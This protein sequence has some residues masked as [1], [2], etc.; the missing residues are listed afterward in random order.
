M[1][2]KKDTSKLQKKAIIDKK[3]KRTTVYV[4]MAGVESKSVLTRILEF[5]GF[6]NKEQ[7][8]TMVRTEY[9]K[10]NIQEKFDITPKEWMNHVYEYF[11]HKNKWDGYFSS[12]PASKTAVTNKKATGRPSEK[13]AM[14]LHPEGH[15][16][17]LSVL[18]FIHDTYQKTQPDH[19]SEDNF[20][21]MPGTGSTL[22]KI[23]DRIHQ[24]SDMLD[25]K[26]KRKHVESD[27]VITRIDDK[28][29]HYKDI[30]GNG[31]GM[32]SFQSYK[33]MRASGELTPV[34]ENN[35]DTMPDVSQM[36]ISDRVLEAER[37][38]TLAYQNGKTATPALDQKVIN[39]TAGLPLGGGGNKI[40]AAWSN[41]W[42]RANL[43]ATGGH[44]PV[45]PATTPAPNPDD[46]YQE[47]QEAA[48]TT[49]YGKNFK[50]MEA[51]GIL[52]VK[53]YA[54]IEN[55]PYMPLSIDR[56]R[57][58]TDKDGQYI[59]FAIAHNYIQNGDVM[60]DPDMEIRVRPQFGS[61][62]ALTFQNDGVGVFTEVYPEAGK[63]NLRAKKDLNSFLTTWLNNLK[64][65]G[66]QYKLGETNGPNKS[67]AGSGEVSATDATVLAGAA[68]GSTLKDVPETKPG[69]YRGELVLDG[70]EFRERSAADVRLTPKQAKEIREQVHTLLNS[71][72]DDAM[73]DTEKALLMQ[74]EGAGGLHE[75]EATTH[76]TLYEFYTPKTVVDK[77]W[78]LTE[79]YAGKG[80]EVLEPSCGTGRFANRDG[81]KFDMIEIDPTSARIA[82]ILNP[83]QNVKQ[84]AFQEIFYKNGAP[85]EKYSGKKY[86]V[87]IGNPPYGEYSGIHKGKGE[88]KSHKR[89]E[90]YFID[91]GLDVLKEGGIMTFVVP[92]DFL[93]KES[94]KK[95][96]EKLA[97][98]GRLLE[99]WRLPNGTFNT[100]GVG[101]DILV[102]R[103][104]KGNVAD[105]LGDG[106]FNQ[107]P[108]CILGEQVTKTGKFGPMKYVQPKDNM[109]FADVFN[110]LNTN[111]FNPVSVGQPT[112]TEE[113]KQKIAIA[114]QGNQNAASAHDV[115]AKTKYS[116]I[117]TKKL[118][119]SYEVMQKK[120]D[121]TEQQ[122]NNYSEMERELL[123]RGTIK[124]PSITDTVDQSKFRKEVQQLEK[125][126]KTGKE[127]SPEEKRQYRNVTDKLQIEP[128]ATAIPAELQGE[129]SAQEFSAKYNKQ[130]DALDLDIWKATG[131][132]GAVD[133]AKLSPKARD[134]FTSSDKYCMMAGK[135]YHVS[136]YVSGDIYAKLD[137]LERDKD[138]MPIGLYN[139]QKELLLKAMPAR[140]TIQNVSVSPISEYAKTFNFGIV[141]TPDM[142]IDKFYE[143]ATGKKAD[144]YYGK[145]GMN[146]DGNV[147]R[148]DFPAGIGWSDVVDYIEQKPVRASNKGDKA[149]NQAI[150][151]RTREMRRQ[152][153]EKLFKRFLETGLSADDQKTFEDRHNRIFNSNVDPD[154]SNIPIFVNGISKTFK[155]KELVVQPHQL[156]GTSFLCN[157]GNGLIAYDV[158]LGKTLVGAMATVNQIQTTRAKRPVLCIPK[159]VYEN[160]LAEIRDLFP[161]IKINELGN[162][163]SQYI[164]NGNPPV[165]EE[166]TLSVMTYEA[167]QNMTFHDETLG[168]V[169]D[170]II[171]GGIA[172]DMLDS[173]QTTKEGMTPREEAQQTEKILEMV[174]R[175]SKTKDNM[176]Y[177]EDL[178]FDHITIDEVHNF[179][180]VFARAKPTGKEGQA[181]A[182]EFGDITGSQSDRAMKMFAVTQYIQKNNN[183]R[184]VFALSATPFTNSPLEI[185][186]ILSL[187][188]RKKLK[189]LGIY[190]LHE[191]MAKFAKL[192]TEWV[193]ATDG[194]IKKKAVMKEFQNLG[195]LQNLIIEYIDKID[196]EE[197]GIER[198]RDFNHI[199]ELPMTADQRA[200]MMAEQER[201]KADKDE[202]PGAALK[203]IN[204]MRMSTMSMKMVNFDKYHQ[205][206]DISDTKLVEDSPKLKF[207]A[208]V[209]ANVY[210]ERPEVGQVIYMPR[211]IEHYGEVV[212]YLIS[213]GIPRDAI[214]TIH[215]QMAGGRDKVETIKAEFNDPKGKIKVLIGSET[216][217][218]GINLNGNS[219][220]LYNTLLGWNPS[221]RT[222][223]KGRIWRQGNLQENVHIVYPQIINSVDSAMYQKH[224]EKGARFEQVWSYKGDNLNVED[225]NAEELKFSLIKDP[226]KRAKFQLDLELEKIDNDKRDIRIGIDMLNKNKEDLGNAAYR[227]SSVKDDIERS[228][229]TLAT[230]Q[231]DYDEVKE[232]YDA[233][234]KV[235][236]GEKDP[237]ATYRQQ[238]ER[239]L[240]NELSYV[241]RAKDQIRGYN[242]DIKKINDQIDRI[243]AKLKDMGITAEQIPM[244]V[245]KQE[246]EIEKLVE[247]EKAMKAEL[248]RLIEKAKR[249][250]KANE[251]EVPT[252]EKSVQTYTDLLLKT[253]KY[254]E[255]K[256]AL[257]MFFTSNTILKARIQ[258][259]NG[260][261]YLV[262]MPT[263]TGIPGECAEL[264]KATNRGRLQKKVI[265]NKL[266]K[267][268][269]VW[270]AP[271]Q[272]EPGPKEKKGEYQGKDKKLAQDKKPE[273]VLGILK[274]KQQEVSAQLD[275]LQASYSPDDIQ[276]NKDGSKDKFTK[277]ALEKMR[278][279]NHMQRI[280]NAQI[281]KDATVKEAKKAGRERVKNAIKNFITTLTET[282]SGHGGADE[283][284]D[285]VHTAGEDTARKGEAVKK[286]QEAKSKEQQAQQEAK[287]VT[288]G[289]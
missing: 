99:A 47:Q 232:R 37:L 145:M 91:R 93:R 267:K 143:W 226:E 123:K 256:K 220:I 111:Q 15:I 2:G 228:D 183:D 242:M 217:K 12:R 185:Y 52:G 237:H 66:F 68:A 198:P 270:V 155:G 252:V 188:A 3:G 73:T 135:A 51:L 30:D 219:A 268:Q 121:M 133:I 245:K 160:W 280:N 53:E 152:I 233:I 235:K 62:E 43:T 258:L 18:N 149:N 114:M 1:L 124:Q 208:D 177:F 229:R 23:G 118:K 79:K 174:G 150:A 274:Q 285:T 96:K 38:G 80:A 131:Y 20:E 236:K 138:F 176:I 81:H 260:K 69:D 104:E 32:I 223:V 128:G 95:I 141:E 283:A 277:L 259:R 127:L 194:T 61:V 231:K 278:L 142:L 199:V 175:G 103:K 88:G 86:D 130:F 221:E 75:D 206:I 187:V 9:A 106:F 113:G 112:M 5:F 97:E 33:D 240:D 117:N 273:E 89:Y 279:E 83:G 224:D 92:S 46:T 100:T 148:H 64:H 85:Q 50:R 78:D 200:L 179:K 7:F 255:L 60:A 284:V 184:N 63:V 27:F 76:G 193:A 165:I 55:P 239:E 6:K 250:I 82:K 139:R 13:S 34:A 4:K 19:Q 67:E 276:A 203:A 16:L 48:A 204:N 58:G 265:T 156:R 84:G 151:E 56:L 129:M 28:Y 25:K 247:R 125:K 253:I 31:S 167:L 243:N 132:D 8:V 249:D 216:I 108:D 264:L 214:A 109:A 192:K 168:I 190:N 282:F 153:A 230:Y 215:S 251:K 98:K 210:K 173:Q 154:Y 59:D 195:E 44:P 288:N 261:L 244:E 35:F 189:Q 87:V 211:G 41:A 238:A 180:N 254:K 263:T 90:E 213:K 169:G 289:R 94:N 171:V 222:Q 120:P 40:L 140:K 197:A 29:V 241:K 212:S 158:G 14:I 161:N 71:K 181:M 22:P 191:F 225:I 262:Q 137:Q 144:T 202:E 266:G 146:F 269:T 134:G 162:L 65:Q 10:Q 21:T 159:A 119:E 110:L 272:P 102:I 186:N 275:T 218:E 147:T 42:H 11:S 234:P 163:G 72:Q 207:V 115:M 122:Y 101:T 209:T 57:A 248:P 39:L 26:L 281:Q 257:T 116:G 17:K 178:G 54:K 45:T 136:N 49:V 172:Q 166:G 70:G 36:S 205:G 287:K 182:N 105:F 246:Q 271:D 170:K 196:G 286:K 107:H 77:M 227:I 201:F 74:Y 157:K 164:T 24:S 126:I